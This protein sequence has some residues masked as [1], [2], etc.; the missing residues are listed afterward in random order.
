MALAEKLGREFFD[1]D[2]VIEL[3]AGADIGW[4]FDVEGEFG[5]RKREAAVLADLCQSKKGIV[6]ST[7]GGAVVL[8][9]NRQV[10]AK[11]GTV[12]SDSQTF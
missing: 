1:S 7:G 12:L 6:L 5:Y 10:L 2:Q 4:I 11:N 3:R 9:E 8:P